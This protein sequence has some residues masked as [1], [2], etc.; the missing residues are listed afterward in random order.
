MK[1]SSVSMI[2]AKNQSN[3]MEAYDVKSYWLPFTSNRA[4]KKGP[5]II[6]SA[7]GNYYQDDRGRNIFDGLSGLW[8]CGAGHARP[9]IIEAITQQAQQLDYSPS[10]NFAH[11]KAFQ[12]ASRI[13]ELTPEDLNHVFFAGS[14][15]ESVETAIKIAK[16]YWRHQG[17]SSKT[18]IIGRM[19]GYHGVNIGGIS[20]GGIGANRAHFGPGIDADHLRHTV[21]PENAF[22]SRLT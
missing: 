19:R 7:K 11:P 13:A 17:Q 8:T 4:F 18:K 2:Q 20:V 15:S 21:L 6:V 3:S 10:F 16:A 1:S 5:R 22:S 14:G 9:E 12:L